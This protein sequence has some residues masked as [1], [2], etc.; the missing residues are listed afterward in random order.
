MSVAAPASLARVGEGTTELRISPSADE[1]GQV[2]PEHA[3][4]WQRQGRFMIYQL[5]AG[6][7]CL[8]IGGQPMLWAVL[9]EGDCIKVGAHVMRFQLVG[10]GAEA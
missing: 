7:P 4:I 3:R 9:E 1:D 10:P 5:A 8:L 6:R 2:A